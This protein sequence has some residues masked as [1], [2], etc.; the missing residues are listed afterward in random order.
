MLGAPRGDVL[1]RA[2]NINVPCDGISR[3]LTSALPQ[4]PPP[5]APSPFLTNQSTENSAGGLM[6]NA[7]MDVIPV[8]YTDGTQGE[9]RHAVGLLQRHVARA[10]VE[11]GVRGRSMS[12]GPA[13]RRKIE[14]VVGVLE[15]FEGR[16]R[17]ASTVSS[18]AT[19][20]RSSTHH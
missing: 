4:P 7:G 10:L 11:V 5:P 1:C 13:E 20:R 12:F 3:V 8:F 9:H 6:T 15:R 14:K 18:Q 17:S 19:P 16:S 2:Q